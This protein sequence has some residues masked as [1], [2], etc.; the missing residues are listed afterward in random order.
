[1]P[2]VKGENYLTNVDGFIISDN[3]T[4]TAENIDGEYMYSDHNPVK[5]EFTLE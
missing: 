1:M 4:A 3:I 5:I 2:Y